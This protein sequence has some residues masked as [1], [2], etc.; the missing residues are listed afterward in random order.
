MLNILFIIAIIIAAVLIYASTRPD[1]FRV[2]RSIII[3][4]PLEKVFP[5]IND[6]HSWEA[7]SPWEKADPNVKRSYDGPRSGVGSKY[8][9]LGNKQ[10]GSGEMELVESVPNSHVGIKIHFIKPFE[11]RNKVDFDLV[12]QGN[13]T[14]VTHAMNGPS[15]FISKLMSLVFNMEKMVGPKFEEGLASIKAMAEK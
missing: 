8:A 10:L 1:S 11:A 5:V 3:N 6:F 12:A 13:G 4:A 2:E 15:P 9:W 7:W 14:K